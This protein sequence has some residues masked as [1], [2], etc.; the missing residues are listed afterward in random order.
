MPNNRS[1]HS[2]QDA[3]SLIERIVARDPA[4]RGIANLVQW[5]A[6]YAAA[7][8]LWGT[9][10]T[11]IIS[12]FFLPAAKVGETDGPPGAKALGRALETLGAD[13]V[14]LTDT[15]NAPL[16]AAL[17]L[18]RVEVYRPNMLPGLNVTHLVSIERPGRAQDGHYYSMSARDISEFTAPLDELF[19]QARALQTATVA[20]GDGGN[21]IGMGNVRERVRSDVLH[22]EKIA[23]VVECDHLVVAGVSNWGAYGLVGALSVLAG[24][25]LLPG[26]AEAE[27]DIRA[28]VRA[29]AADGQTFRNEPT[30]DSQSL[31]DNLAVLEEIRGVAL[32]ARR[33]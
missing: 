25:D 5:G 3:V 1:M 19:L 11:G 24:R 10:K 29:G 33:T 12:G 18:A 31:A 17:G 21:E 9:R 14:Y 6:L 13:V 27:E 32:T 23:C 28:I 26:A 22:G 2:A 16:F 15:W 4:A 20:I 8:A 30:V 7:R